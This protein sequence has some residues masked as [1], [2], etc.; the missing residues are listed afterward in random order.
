LD[1]QLA[2]RREVILRRRAARGEKFHGSAEIRKNRRKDFKQRA[3]LAKQTRARPL[4]EFKEQHLGLTPEE[5][6]RA[7]AKG[8]TLDDVLAYYKQAGGLDKRF[9]SGPTEETYPADSHQ[10]MIR[11]ARRYGLSEKRE[12]AQ[13]DADITIKNPKGAGRPEAD[14]DIPESLKETNR[15]LELADRINSGIDLANIP[16]LYDTAH[17][18]STKL[19]AVVTWLVTGN[20]TK[21]AKYLSVSYK[22]VCKWRRESEWWPLVAS[23][24]QREFGDVLDHDL[25]DI[26]H[27]STELVRDRLEGGDYKYNAKLDKL[28]RVPV[29]AKDAVQIMD[30][31]ITN[32]NLLRGDPTSRSEQV[33]ASENLTFL[34]SEFAK[35]AAAKTIEGDTDDTSE[36]ND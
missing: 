8:L 12:N 17:S 35:F 9:L 3:E 34:R 1:E 24:V 2:A 28:V 32:R 19:H 21:T 13:N 10:R 30:K 22:T 7:V 6:E 29:P 36:S 25:T 11:M 5:Y 4:N 16:G 20:L 26:I 18:P 27:S 14:L 31:A 23:Q 15:I 33:T